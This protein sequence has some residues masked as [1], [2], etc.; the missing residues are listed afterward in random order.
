MLDKPD[1]E[2]VIVTEAGKSILISIVPASPS[3][4]EATERFPEPNEDLKC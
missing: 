1:Q 4:I 2:R 3:V